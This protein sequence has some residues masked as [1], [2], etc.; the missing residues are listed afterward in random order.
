MNTIASRCWLSL[1]KPNHLNF[2]CITI[3]IL[4]FI[5]SCQPRKIQMY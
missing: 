1:R 3:I 2:I 4:L 5:A